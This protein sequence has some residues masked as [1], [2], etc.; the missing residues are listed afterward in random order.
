MDASRD[1]FGHMLYDYF[2]GKEVYDVIERD[3]GYITVPDSIGLYFAE[4]EDW[5]ENDRIA[6]DF[7]I[8]RV[9][10]IG[11]G[12]GR[13]ALYLQN[14]GHYVLGI[15]SSPLAVYISQERGLL[16]A[17]LCSVTRVSSKLGHFDTLLLLGNNVG[18]LANK[19]RA[20]WLMRRFHSMTSPSARIIAGSSNHYVTDD[21]VHLA[22]FEKNR[23]AGRLPGQVRIRYRY[24]SYKDDWFDYLFV[25]KKEMAEIIQGTGWHIEHTIGDGGPLYVLILEKNADY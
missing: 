3:D 6:V 11:V 4:R 19:G 10:D 22:Y 20:K 12:A 25:S 9:L 14:H 2:K 8:G 5:P 23:S 24:Q 7:A 15:D 21:P 1:A 16:N 18:L 17:R 13:H